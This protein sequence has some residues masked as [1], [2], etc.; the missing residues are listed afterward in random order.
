MTTFFYLT[1][2]DDVRHRV[3]YEANANIWHWTTNRLGPNRFT[4]INLI[5]PEEERSLIEISIS[6]SQVLL[7]P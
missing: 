5:F 2:D 1:V 4:T 7:L 3:L 6:P